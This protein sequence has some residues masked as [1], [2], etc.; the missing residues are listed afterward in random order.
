MKNKIS[1]KILAIVLLTGLSIFSFPLMSHADDDDGGSPATCQVGGGDDDDGGSS[2][3]N[4]CVTPTPQVPSNKV[5]MELMLS[6]DVSGSI[7]PAEYD[8][9]K[10]GYI[11]AFRSKKVQDA[12]ELLPNGLAVAM[13][14]WSGNIQKTSSWYKVT[15]AAEAESFANVIA[16]TLDQNRGR[17]ST[18]ITKAIQS[19]ATGLVT[20]P[21][22]GDVLVID[23][24]GDGFDNTAINGRNSRCSRM[25]GTPVAQVT[26]VPL[27][28]ARDNA[29]ANGIIINGLPIVSKQPQKDRQHELAPYYQNNV[30]GGLNPSTGGTTKLNGEPVAFI[31]I[32]QDF[33]DFADAVAVKIE[34]EI[35]TTI[36]IAPP[37]P[38]PNANRDP[39]VINDTASTRLSSVLVDVLANDSDPDGD[40][41]TI[42]R[43]SQGQ[44]GRT[45]IRNGQV[46]YR[47]NRGFTGV[48]TFTYTAIDGK[49][50]S[51]TA[52]VT[53]NV[54]P[55]PPLPP[56]DDDPTPPVVIII[57]D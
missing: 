23:I 30:I 45:S 1:K 8:L 36:E 25:I 3:S 37:N 20:N 15:T 9:Q 17:G 50:G 16:S 12:I 26:C 38:D 27:Q 29:I 43:A 32:A 31:Q 33:E 42:R 11:N 14:T 13:E 22:D 40:T 4:N 21:Y 35:I 34:K 18:H 57:A 5:T 56:K 55:Q 41:L 51:G 44:N 24:S 49:G 48:D 47:P 10:R 7:N 46:R 28:S 53:V 52:T 6:V 19:G 54:G 2:V 39:Y